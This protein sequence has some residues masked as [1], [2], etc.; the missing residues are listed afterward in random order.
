MFFAG[1]GYNHLPEESRARWADV[2]FE[3]IEAAV[4]VQSQLPAV[5]TEVHS[6]VKAAF[7]RRQNFREQAQQD[8]LEQWNKARVK[9]L[10]VRR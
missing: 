8:A 1:G 4:S 6:L 7:D 9:A 10:L 2:L 5:L 3:C